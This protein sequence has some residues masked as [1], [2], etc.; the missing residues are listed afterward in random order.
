[1]DIAGRVIESKTGVTFGESIQ[2]GKQ[3]K[4]GT[5]LVEVRQGQNIK[6]LKLVKL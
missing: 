6:L 5:Y 4:A 1:M 2:L 3:Y